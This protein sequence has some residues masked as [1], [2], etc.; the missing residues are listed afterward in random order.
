MILRILPL[1]LS[2]KWHFNL[3]F[4]PSV[5]YF[6]QFKIKKLIVTGNCSRNFK[7]KTVFQEISLYAVDSVELER[8]WKVRVDESAQESVDTLEFRRLQSKIYETSTSGELISSFV[9]FL[10]D[11]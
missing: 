11:K 9:Q 2:F 7:H 3:Y 5:L 10:L 8:S 4:P 6:G 1:K